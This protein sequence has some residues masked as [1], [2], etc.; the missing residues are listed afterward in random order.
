MNDH[1]ERIAIMQDNELDLIAQLE[2]IDIAIAVQL[3]RKRTMTRS[4]RRTR[5][6]LKDAVADAT[7]EQTPVRA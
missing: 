2:R 6:N 5:H 3:T 7:E 1:D 4:L